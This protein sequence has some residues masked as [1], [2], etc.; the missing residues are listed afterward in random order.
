MLKYYNFQK[1][2]SVTAN[3]TWG[4]WIELLSLKDISKIKYYVIQC[5][6][7]LSTTRQ[8]RERIKNKEYERLDD[9]TKEKL[10][11]SNETSVL[12]SVRKIISL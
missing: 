8:L 3:L 10:I 4:H 6:K 9:K 1:M 7:L 11:S 2:Q 5:E 12:L